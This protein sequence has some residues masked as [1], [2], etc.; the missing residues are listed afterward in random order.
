MNRER[1]NYMRLC[2]VGVSP[3]IGIGTAYVVHIREID[4]SKRQ[5]PPGESTRFFRAIE[6]LT[7]ILQQ[8]A[9]AAPGERSEILE[10]HIMLLCD[11][12]LRSDI[13]GMINAEHLSSEYAVHTVFERFANYFLETLRYLYWG[14]QAHY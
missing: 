12:I 11:P 7:T 2:G 8:R 5:A 9:R 3:G 4:V 14:R 6:D 10:S 13:E 1:Y